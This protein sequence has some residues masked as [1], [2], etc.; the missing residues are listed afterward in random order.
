MSS[1]RQARELAVQFLYQLEATGDEL[2]EGLDKFKEVYGLPDKAAPFFE[3][4]VRGVWRH[5]RELDKLIGHYSK[6]WKVD[7]MS[8]ID[9]IILRLAA[10]EMKYCPDIP[11][12]ATIN[13]AVELAKSF[14]GDESSRFINGVADALNKDLQKTDPAE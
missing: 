1:R 12:N 2:D 13:E 7:R 9:R 14:C 11:A 6:N 8:V 10:F 3:R 4:L 5:D